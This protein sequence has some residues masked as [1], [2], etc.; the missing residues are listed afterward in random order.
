VPEVF[1]S[2]VLS[3]TADG[4]VTRVPLRNRFR[5]AGPIDG[6][7]SA[8]MCFLSTSREVRKA[9][10]EIFCIAESKPDGAPHGKIGFDRCHHPF[11]S[12]HG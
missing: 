6:C 2:K 9:S 8:D 12:G 3:E 1:H 5:L 7:C 11:T 10:Q 4:A